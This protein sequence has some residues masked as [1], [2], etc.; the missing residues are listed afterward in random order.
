[1]IGFAACSAQSGGTTDDGT[2]GSQNNGG[3]GGSAGRGGSGGRGGSPGGA[4]G[5]D[6]G[7]GGNNQGTGGSNPGTGGNNPGGA[8]GQAQTGDL[9]PYKV[10]NRWEYDVHELLTGLKFTKV[11]TVVRME[12]VGG[13]GP[14]ATKMA[15]RAETVKQDPISPDGTISWQAVEGSMVVRYREQTCK[16]G[17]LKM[18]G[19]Q[20]MSCTPSEDDYW[21]PY[22]LRLDQM[23]DGKPLAMGL[24]W[25]ETFMETKAV[26]SYKLNPNMP[27]IMESTSMPTEKWEVV[28]MGVTATAPAGEFKNCVALKKTAASGMTKT[29]TFCPG[30]GKVIEEGS[31]QTE[32]LIKHSLQ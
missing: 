16:A 12:M 5:S 6:P 22:R 11:N 4:G 18:M 7:M 9:F 20:I 10:G 26:Y 1:M 29:Y 13:K 21:T 2:G 17:S 15:L 14:N 25:D 8:G 24:K 19:D 27:T 3:R 23:P 28:G 32:K 30:V 31:G